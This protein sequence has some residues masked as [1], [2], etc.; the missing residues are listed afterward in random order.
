MAKEHISVQ[1]PCTGGINPWLASMLTTLKSL[2]SEP[3]CPYHFSVGI[4]SHLHPADYARNVIVKEVLQTDASRLWFIDS[5]VK[6]SENCIQIL[7]WSG[8][9]VAGIYPMWGQ[10]HRDQPEPPSVHWCVYDRKGDTFVPQ[11]ILESGVVDCGAAGTGMMVIRRAVL[12]DERM[13]LPGEYVGL[14]GKAMTLPEDAPPALFKEIHAPNGRFDSTEDI[15]F[16]FRAADLGY[17]IKADHSVKCGHLK[18]IDVKDVASYSVDCV[19]YGFR[20]GVLSVREQRQ[21]EDRRLVIAS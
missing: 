1:V 2:N 14:G 3:S 13:R 17:S 21:E 10:L 19:G 7:K 11:E 16:C 12:E 5:D 8:D 6:P 20:R 15:D 4:V 18:F 9:I